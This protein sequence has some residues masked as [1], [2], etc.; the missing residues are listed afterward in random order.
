MPGNARWSS[1]GNARISETDTSRTSAASTRRS[2]TRGRR[3]LR[4]LCRS[5]NLLAVLQRATGKPAGSVFIFNFTVANE[6]ELMAAYIIREMVVISVSWKELQKID[7]ECR[8]DTHSTTHICAVQSLHKRGTHTTRLAQVT[9]IAV[10][11]L[12]A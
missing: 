11:S 9:R 10:S 1:G 12:C 8:Q 3:K 2:T 6:L 7:G 5:Q 4:L